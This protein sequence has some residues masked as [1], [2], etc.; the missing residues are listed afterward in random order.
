MSIRAGSQVGFSMCQSRM[1]ENLSQQ[2]HLTTQKTEPCSNYH[3]LYP[4]FLEIGRCVIKDDKSLRLA[5]GQLK[6]L[7]KYKIEYIHIHKHN[8][9][10]HYK[11]YFLHHPYKT[12]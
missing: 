9:Y 11:L 10:Y 1:N 4:L 3:S 12:H 8:T 7:I 2:S 5:Q 6:K